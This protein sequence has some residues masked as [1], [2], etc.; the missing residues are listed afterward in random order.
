MRKI[1]L[2]IIILVCFLLYINMS[3]GGKSQSIT[4][5]DELAHKYC[6][7]CHQFNDPSLL[8]KK[9]WG[10]NVLPK[11]A[12]FMYVD[13]YYN[14]YVPGSSQRR[15]APEDLFPYEKW[16][17]I[18]NYYL[19][20][21]PDSMPVRT[22]QLSPV[23]I[24]LNHFTT[25]FIESKIEAP[26]TTMVR[27]DTAGHRILFGDGQERKLFVMNPAMKVVDSFHVR[28]GIADIH[29][30]KN[31][32]EVVTMGILKP[33]DAI[34]GKLVRI[35][36]KKETILA[37]SLERPV[38]ATYADLNGDNKEDIVLCEFGYRLGALSWLE[39]MGNDQYK[40][41]VLRGLP[42]AINT[43]VYDF[44]K[45]GKPD[46]IALMAQADEG[47]FIYY[48]E[49]GGHFREERVLSFPP[50]YGSNSMQLCDLNKDGFMDILVTHGDNADF[51]PVRK[52]Y[53]GIRLFLND[54]K[55]HFRLDKFL[56]VYGVQKAVAADMDN[57]GD[58]DIISVSFFPDYEKAPEESFL[59]WENKGSGQYQRYTF[60]GV[61]D[62]RWMTLDA[63]DMDHDGDKDII[64]ANGTIGFG[65]VPPALKE[66]WISHP[67]SAVVLE[68][69]LIKK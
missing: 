12:E 27:F 35:T 40:K 54:G 1:Y 38:Q 58:P 14:P 20:N 43:E 68:N 8:D 17:K 65:N 50:V 24:G 63:G 3:C 49:G 21:A 30:A 67:V 31:S 59:Y 25:H 10:E 56:P 64:L 51:S 60:E 57:D 62:G 39:N 13:Q 48:N 55:D 2:L 45:D 5:G 22:E 47:V 53:H 18:V 36:D 7:S 4:E 23:H 15:I 6:I 33:S 69:T 32:F 16:E 11:M 61:T 41:H 46:I 34:L 19:L 66:R 52:P 44:N 9:S 26:L 28:V 37:D 42:G 29:L